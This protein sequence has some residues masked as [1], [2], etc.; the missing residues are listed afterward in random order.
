M[1]LEG[2]HDDR[3]DGWSCASGRRHCDVSWRHLFF[4]WS[5]FINVFVLLLC[6]AFGTRWYTA[7]FMGGHITSTDALVIGALISVFTG[8]VYAIYNIV[9]VSFIYPHFLDDLVRFRAA[10]TPLSE[11]TPEI[12]AAMRARITAPRLAWSNFVLLAGTGSLL[13][14]IASP[15][16]KRKRR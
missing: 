7:H 14:L 4:S 10:R 2:A 15:L 12:I 11:Q 16:L 3:V 13:S 8:L 9:S 6:I 1:E 5:I